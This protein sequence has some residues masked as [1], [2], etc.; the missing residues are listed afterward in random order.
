MHFAL[1]KDHELR[2][3]VEDYQAQ[4]NQAIDQLAEYKH[5]A[6]TAE[7][8]VITIAYTMLTLILQVELSETQASTSKVRDLE[9]D[10]KEKNLLIG[11]LRHEGLSTHPPV[12]PRRLTRPLAVILNEHLMEALRRLRRNS[13]ATNVDRRLVSNVLISF[14]STPRADTKRYEM[15]SLL[16]SILSW[17]DDDREKAGLQRAHSANPSSSF[18]VRSP[19]TP[20]TKPAELEKTDET[21]VQNTNKFFWRGLMIPT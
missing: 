1:A 16:A 4:L 12:R 13:S 17:S 7:V 21:E 6:L 10:V 11:K 8:R 9:K 3:A 20:P 19:M 5:R 15:L 14:L 2:Q 18:W